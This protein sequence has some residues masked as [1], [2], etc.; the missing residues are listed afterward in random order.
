MVSEWEVKLE[1]AVGNV[2]IE[3]SSQFDE[4]TADVISRVAFGS[5]HRAANG[6]HS[7]QKELQ[8]LVFSGIFNLL[9]HIP[10]FRYID[11]TSCKKNH[12]VGP[13]QY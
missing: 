4:L 1:K 7:A 8:F 9:S 13:N 12:F 3:M 6:V 10:G 5:D 11:T 2:E